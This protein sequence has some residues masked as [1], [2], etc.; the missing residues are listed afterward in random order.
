MAGL[1]TLADTAAVRKE[2]MAQYAKM[3]A[4]FKRKDAAGVVSTM[5]PD[6]EARVPGG[7]VIRRADMEASMKSQ[8]ATVQSVK[9]MVYK[10]DSLTVKGNTAVATVTGNSSIVILDDDHKPHTVDQINKVRNTWTKTK[11]GWRI[12][13]AE[14][15]GIKV[16]VDGKPLR[17]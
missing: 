11:A 12:K 2:L 3:A 15:L 1:P 14:M 4:A 8:L 6:A 17:Q 7:P 13:V 5:A 9:S 16:F 10:I